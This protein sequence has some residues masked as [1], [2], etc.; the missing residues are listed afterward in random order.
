[1]TRWLLRAV[2]SCTA[3]G[4]WRDARWAVAS[5]RGWPSWLAWTFGRSA[6]RVR[7]S[8]GGMVRFG[9]GECRWLWRTRRTRRRRTVDRCRWRCA[10]GCRVLRRCRGV[11]RWSLSS[12]LSAWE[13]LPA[14]CC[15][16]R[17][18]SE[19][20]CCPLV[21]R[22][23][24]ALAA[25]AALAIPKGEEALLLD[26]SASVGIQG[27]HGP[28]PLARGQKVS[29]HTSVCPGPR[30]SFCMRLKGVHRLLNL[31][32]LVARLTLSFSQ[33]Y[34]ALLMGW[35]NGLDESPASQLSIKTNFA[36]FAEGEVVFWSL[37]AVAKDIFSSWTPLF[38][39]ASLLIFWIFLRTTVSDR[40]KF[41][42][43]TS[44]FSKWQE[45][46][47]F[48]LVIFQVRST[49]T[50]MEFHA[51][52]LRRRCR[53]CG[54][55]IRPLRAAR[56]VAGYADLLLKTYNVDPSQDLPD[57]QPKNCCAS[58]ISYAR[59]ATEST[60][61]GKDRETTRTVYKWSECE[62]AD[63]SLCRVW[64]EEQK[65]GRMSKTEKY[66]TRG[67]PPDQ[68]PLGQQRSPLGLYHS[69]HNHLRHPDGRQPG[70]KGG[71]S[72]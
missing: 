18:R 20:W 68:F 3:A 45:R 16:R 6:R 12:W 72:I 37:S 36:F 62:G 42:L 39:G 27:T 65:P 34:V 55:W 59:R 41:Y 33:F 28:R 7:W 25:T 24:C 52:E 15:A 4:T 23:P 11:C 48:F 21:Q 51:N 9:C 5:L 40:S 38:F 32:Q 19:T 44:T 60:V 64:Q 43:C 22:S 56:P 54:R 10:P 49:V 50:H 17:P 30:P 61:S 70:R 58:C 47:K 8:L 1:M 53:V 35:V 2:C 26:V 63:C 57:V 14:T 67:R 29:R 31:L 46:V 66:G 69:L 13:W 71:V